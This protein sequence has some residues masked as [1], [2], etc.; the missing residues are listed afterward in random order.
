MLKASLV[1]KSSL[2]PEITEEIEDETII[3]C[4]D[5]LKKYIKRKKGEEAKFLDD[6]HIA[7]AHQGEVIPITPNGHAYLNDCQNDWPEGVMDKNRTPEMAAL[8]YFCGLLAILSLLAIW[9]WKHIITL[10]KF[11]KEVQK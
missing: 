3:I 7:G 2:K 11:I 5:C 4:M 8:G 6:H 10:Y 9:G 1:K